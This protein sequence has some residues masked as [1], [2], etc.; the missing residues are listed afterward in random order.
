[1]KLIVALNTSVYVP[2]MSSLHTLQTT[3][4]TQIAVFTRPKVKRFCH[5]QRN[6]KGTE[7]FGRTDDQD[8]YNRC[9]NCSYTNKVLPKGGMKKLVI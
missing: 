4:M 9:F 5:I 6:E 2:K 7:N 8:R 1:M 3:S